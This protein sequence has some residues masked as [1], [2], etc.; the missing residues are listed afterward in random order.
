[1]TLKA[2][3]LTQLALA[4]RPCELAKFSRLVGVTRRG[5]TLTPLPGATL[6]STNPGVVR[7][8][9][10]V[11]IPSLH[12][13]CDGAEEEML[14]CPVRSLRRYEEVVATVRKKGHPFFLPY[15]EQARGKVT[16]TTISTWIKSVIRDAHGALGA[17]DIK[18]A[19]RTAHEVRALA[20]S[21]AD[22]NNV[23]LH[24]ILSTCNWSSATVFS[25]C[26]YRDMSSVSEAMAAV[27]NVV[28]AGRIVLPPAGDTGGLRIRP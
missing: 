3:F 16:A 27:G 13:I 1:M 14:L 5:C 24:E 28:T 18:L 21:W 25:S 23:P 12:E 19:G 22:F 11:H 17:A 7:T 2:A 4:A 9:R 20:A 8:M 15:S 26:Y 6:K 10:D